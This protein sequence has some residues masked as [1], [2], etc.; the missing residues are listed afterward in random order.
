[1]RDFIDVNDLCKIIIFFLKKKSHFSPIY[2][3]ATGKSYSVKEVFDLFSKISKAKLNYIIGDNRKG[4]AFKL[5]CSNKK[6][7]KIYKKR[8]YSLQFSLKNHLKFYRINFR[9]IN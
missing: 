2:N 9:N 7:K 3:L 8:F 4:D 5:V 6:L 1:M